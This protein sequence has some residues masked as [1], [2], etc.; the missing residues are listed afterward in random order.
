M[1]VL[2]RSIFGLVE[3]GSDTISQLLHWPT[4]AASSIFDGSDI[5]EIIDYT[6]STP[7]HRSS[8]H[9][10]HHDSQP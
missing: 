9:G 4:L 7:P 3:M 10:Q 6:Y 5:I 2:Y 1:R 8:Q